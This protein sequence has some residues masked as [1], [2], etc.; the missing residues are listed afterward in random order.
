MARQWHQRHGRDILEIYGSTETGVIAWR[1]QRLAP[2]WQALPSVKLTAT[3]GRLTVTSPFVSAPPEAPAGHHDFVTAD[4]V[5]KPENGRFELLGRTNAII[6]IVGKRV[7]LT[8]I[9]HQ[10]RAC[11]GVSEAAVIAVPATGPVRDLVIWA[12]VIGD[13]NHPLPP[14]QLRTQLR[15]QL[16]D[17]LDGIEVLRRLLVVDALPCAANGKLPR[18]AIASLFTEHDG[19]QQHGHVSL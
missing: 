10:L 6:K 15:S 16:R 13:S 19:K 9:E 8:H 12:A 1:Q 7:S 14:R 5:S 17:Q 18:Q 2:H 3:Q 4:R 11:L